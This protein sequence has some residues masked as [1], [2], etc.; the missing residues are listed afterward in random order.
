MMAINGINE[1]SNSPSPLPTANISSLAQADAGTFR[2]GETQVVVPTRE[3]W[4]TADSWARPEE[5]SNRQA[6]QEAT[7]RAQQFV[8]TGSANIQFVIDNDSERLIVKVIDQDTQDVIR[9]IPSEDMIRLSQALE[10]MQGVFVR[11]AV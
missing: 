9:Q 10:K 4:N 2:S 7:E 3:S 6:L 1:A 5:D 8:S 11:I